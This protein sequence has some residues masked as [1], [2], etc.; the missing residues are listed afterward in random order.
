MDVTKSCT[1]SS[2]NEERER[3]RENNRILQ[4]MRETKQ[5]LKKVAISHLQRKQGRGCEHR[6]RQPLH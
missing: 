1:H 2:F 5:R 3:E 4:A 6:V